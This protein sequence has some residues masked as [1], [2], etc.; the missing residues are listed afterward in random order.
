MHLLL[1]LL[2]GYRY[3]FWKKDQ[4]KISRVTKGYESVHLS[5]VRKL[6][7]INKETKRND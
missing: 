7:E 1:L 2:N 6:Y 4:N 5:D 3:R